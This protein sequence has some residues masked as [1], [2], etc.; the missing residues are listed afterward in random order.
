MKE[1][2]LSSVQEHTF[3]S[4]K[5]EYEGDNTKEENFEITLATEIVGPWKEPLKHNLSEL[6]PEHQKWLQGKARLS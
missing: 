2:L 1:F 5:A 6:Q 3:R 4:W